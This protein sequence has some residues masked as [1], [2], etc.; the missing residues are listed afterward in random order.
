MFHVLNT[1]VPSGTRVS[2][3]GQT[4]ALVK[5][6]V[7]LHGGTV[8]AFSPGLGLGSK[9]TVCLPH[10]PTYAGPPRTESSNS[11][12]IAPGPSLKIMIVDDNADAA[13]MLAMFTDALGHQLFVEPARSRRWLAPASSSLTYFYWILDCRTWM[14][15]NSRGGCAA[16]PKLPRR[17]WWR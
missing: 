8:T 11:I 5:S 14:A 1:R 10:L 16:S 6:L 7:E 4:L 2:H 9:F 12:D 15:M 17:C 13:D 3:S